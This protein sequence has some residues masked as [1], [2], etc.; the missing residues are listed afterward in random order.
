MFAPHTWSRWRWWHVANVA[1][2]LLILLMASPAGAGDISEPGDVQQGVPLEIT[3]TLEPPAAEVNRFLVA[4]G[5]NPLIPGRGTEVAQGEVDWTGKFTMNLYL[6]QDA[7]GGMPVVEGIEVNEAG[8]TIDQS[9]VEMS[10]ANLPAGVRFHANDITSAVGQRSAS[11]VTPTGMNTAGVYQFAAGDLFVSQ[12]SGLAMVS[13]D[14]RPSE[15]QNLE[16]N[17]P[18]VLGLDAISSLAIEPVSGY[19]SPTYRATFRL[20]LSSQTVAYSGTG[21]PVDFHYTSGEMVASGMFSLSSNAVPE[22]SSVVIVAIGI[23]AVALQRA[24][25]VG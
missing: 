17:P 10:Y 5:L 6:K 8:G 20:P 1:S 19:E 4:T 7:G 23:A 15:R 24:K 16:S 25:R 14:T 18:P 22:P 9:S 13:L 12:M 21:L 2:L 11:L 3:L